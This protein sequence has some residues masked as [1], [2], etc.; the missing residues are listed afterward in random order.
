MRKPIVAGN[1]KMNKTVDEAEALVLEVVEAVGGQDGVDVV[2][3]PPYVALERVA[4]AVQ[5]SLVG[6]GAQNMHWEAEGAYTGE[7]S[8]SMLLTCGCR[9]VILGHSERR[10]YFGET[11][12]MVNQRLRAALQAGL[13]PI[14][15]VGETLEERKSEVTEKVIRKQLTGAFQEISAQETAGTIVAYE[16]VWAIGTGLTATPEQ[17]QA[18]HAFVREVLGQLFDAKTSEAVRI[19]YGGSVKPDNASEL[20]SQPDIDGGLIGGAALKADS[21]AAIVQAA[22]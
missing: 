8:A 19:Q 7:I 18:V 17:A 1:W 21:F 16:P 20:F 6:V 14:V 10:T 11:D 5:G 13:V 12:E 9:Y 2:V 3:C 22:L 4:G 15:C